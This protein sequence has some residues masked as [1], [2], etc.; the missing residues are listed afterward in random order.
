MTPRPAVFLDRDGTLVREVD[1]LRGPEELEVLSGVTAGLRELEAAG[2][3]RVVVTNQS[4]VARGYLTEDTLAEIHTRMEAM[5][6]TEGATLDGIYHCPHHPTEGE[7]PFRLAC[8]CR[9]PLPGMIDRAAR[10][11]GLDLERSWTIGDSGRDLE[12]GAARGVRGILVATGKG[13]REHARL[14]AEGRPPA[15]WVPD[16]TAAVEIVLAERQ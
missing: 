10:E 6:G 1:F 2:F 15:F 14:E 16:F 5:L 8:D 4:G 9:K 3:A 13:E 11:L 7:P 12:A